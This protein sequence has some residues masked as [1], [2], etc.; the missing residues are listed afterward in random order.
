[1]TGLW[2]SVLDLQNCLCVA[3]LMS[4]CDRPVVVSV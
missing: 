3:G 1:M 2:L 4:V